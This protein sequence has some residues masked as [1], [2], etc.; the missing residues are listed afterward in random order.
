LLQVN[1]RKN[2]EFQI[3]DSEED[4]INILKSKFSSR[5]L[6]IKYAIEK[7][8]VTINEYLPDGTLMLVTDPNYLNEG[9][10]ISLYGLSDKYIEFMFDV[11]EE[12]GPGYFQCKIKSCFKAIRGRRDLRFKMAPDDV[13]A[14][15]F[16]VSKHTIDV[17]ALNIPTSIKVVLEQFQSQN[18][19]MSDIVKVEVF[20]SD[21]KD[22]VLVQLKKTGKNI[23]VHNVSDPG[24]YKA[25]NDD[26]IDLNEVYAEDTPAVI[27]RY[28]ERGYKSILVVP[29]IYITESISSV[30][31]AY[32]QLISKS[33][34][35]TLD[36]VLDLKDQSFK[37]VD[38]IR[39]A[40]TL[41]I[42][43]HQRIMDISRGG[44][45]LKITDKN[46][47]KYILKS[48]G[49]VFDLVFKLQAP[50]TIFGEAKVTYT[51]DDGNLYVGVDFEGNS[52]RKN[53]MKRYYSILKPMETDY[54]TKL[55]KSM[56]SRKKESKP[57]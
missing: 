50:I 48:K 40:N 42:P 15:N 12:R 19:K 55:I 22:R 54:R 47:Q 38:R 5:K 34:H 1:Q 8:E 37:L 26:F 51:D 14:T 30:P 52:S 36:D 10:S 32:I 57:L 56:K 46:L 20:K 3:I 6:Y 24:S 11:V 2:R 17:T 4:I 29:L 13:I 35:F 23:F 49:F 9:S 16:K 31:F 7:T 25:L 41:L 21:D 53:E 27:K 44:A 33:K 45:K 28:I 18:S 39:D 43:I